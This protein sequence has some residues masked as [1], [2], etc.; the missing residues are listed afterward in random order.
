M[1]RRD[2]DEDEVIEA[3][4]DQRVAH[5][6]RNE[7]R[8]SRLHNA[9]FWTE[10]HEA[11]A[12]KDVI[13]VLSGSGAGRPRAVGG[14]AHAFNEHVEVACSPTRVAL[15]SGLIDDLFWAF[16]PCSA[17]AYPHTRLRVRG[18]GA[19]ALL[20]EASH[21]RNARRYRRGRRRGPRAIYRQPPPAG[22]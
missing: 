5:A 14:G 16:K 17:P 18:R 19:P 10:S 12:D 11:A 6:R 20:T 13:H 3:V 22:Q 2:Y 7:D 15:P 1:W 9:C 4:I 21:R 8:I